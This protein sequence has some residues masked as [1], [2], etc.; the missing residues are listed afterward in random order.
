VRDAERSKPDEA[1]WV[2]KCA[3]VTYRLALIPD[4]AWKVEQ[5]E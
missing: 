4:M 1:A 3:N 2:L 5:L